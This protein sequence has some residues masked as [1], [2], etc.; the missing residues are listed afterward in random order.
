MP[1]FFFHIQKP[2]NELIKD[3]EGIELED[4]EA[5]RSEA[6]HAARDLL[7]EAAREGRDDRKKKF[8]ITNDQ[9]EE[10]LS[11]HFEEAFQEEQ[12]R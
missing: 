9:G 5:A 8:V 10:V 3:D 1:L 4:I 2:D 7:G 12:V 6:I 11:V